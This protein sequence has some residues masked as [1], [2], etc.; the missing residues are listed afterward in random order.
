MAR[1]DAL[2]ARFG[3]GT[4][5]LASRVLPPAAPARAPWQGQVRWQSPAFTTRLKDLL[6]EPV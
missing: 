6:A 4:V 5:Q 3:R 1:L 2:N